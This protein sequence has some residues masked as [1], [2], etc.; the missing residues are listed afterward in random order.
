MSGHHTIN[1]SYTSHKNNCLAK[2]RRAWLSQSARG[3]F[4]AVVFAATID[5]KHCYGFYVVANLHFTAVFMLWW[6]I[7]FN[8]TIQCLGLYL[9]VSRRATLSTRLWQPSESATSWWRISGVTLNFRWRST[10]T[11]SWTLL[12]LI[13]AKVFFLCKVPILSSYLPYMCIFDCNTHLYTLEHTCILKYIQ[14]Y[15]IQ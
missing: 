3:F 12:S 9:F 6:P 11:S 1:F 13:W 5:L 8:F 14:V 10:S 7:I 15:S 4:L 2:W